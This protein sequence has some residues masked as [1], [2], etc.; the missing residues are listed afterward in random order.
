MRFKWDIIVVALVS[1]AAGF[2]GSYILLETEKV[3]VAANQLVSKQ[4]YFK[5]RCNEIKKLHQEMNDHFQAIS[6]SQSSDEK[7]IHLASLRSNEQ[8]AIT[9]LN[10]KSY[11]IYENEYHKIKNKKNTTKPFESSIPSMLGLREELRVCNTFE[12]YPTK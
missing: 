7:N 2:F 3:K 6:I 12:N 10:K 4:T 1:S 9:Y 5:E 11:S 8:T